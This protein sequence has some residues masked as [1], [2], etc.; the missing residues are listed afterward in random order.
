MDDRIIED[1]ADMCESVEFESMIESMERPY[2]KPQTEDVSPTPELLDYL[3]DVVLDTLYRNADLVHEAC[4]IW[5]LS[6]PQAT[7]I[8][9]TR[10]LA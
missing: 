10:S 4:G 6:H 8:P 5:L 2:S 9:T 7:G 1:Q 3:T